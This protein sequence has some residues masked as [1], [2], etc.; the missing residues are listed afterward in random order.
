MVPMAEA[1]EAACEKGQARSHDFF[2]DL[3]VL[4]CHSAYGIL[5]VHTY[6]Y[7]IVESDRRTALFF[8][9]V[10]ANQAINH[11]GFLH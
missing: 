11:G 3:D 8:V 4:S 2:P 6:G 7:G 10:V 5:R 1:E 9:A